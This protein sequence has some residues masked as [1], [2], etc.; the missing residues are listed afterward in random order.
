[1]QIDDQYFLHLRNHGNTHV[2]ISEI[3]YL[4]PGKEEPVSAPAA[5]YI[6]AGQ[7]G[8]VS[9]QLHGDAVE[10]KVTL[11]TDTLGNMEYELSPSS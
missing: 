4:A 5:I 10:G 6:L 7:T 2:K 1:M 9:I 11:V 3:Q 8:F